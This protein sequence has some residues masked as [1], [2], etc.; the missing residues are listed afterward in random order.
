MAVA[1]FAASVA[2]G[3]LL[4][5]VLFPLAFVYPDAAG[6]L[7]AGL[8]VVARMHGLRA[9]AAGAA[10][11]LGFGLAVV[12]LASGDSLQAAGAAVALGF[13]LG[14]AIE[15]SSGARP[16]PGSPSPPRHAAPL[17]LGVRQ[18]V[19]PGL[20]P[21]PARGHR[22][23]GPAGPSRGADARRGGCGVAPGAGPIRAGPAPVLPSG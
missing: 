1:L 12:N 4:A 5:G 20:R 6:S 22:V 13:G 23:P 10:V 14:S 3:P 11:A 9:P 15:P 7:D 16:G 17:A 19:L 18:P 8:A 21:P 2:V